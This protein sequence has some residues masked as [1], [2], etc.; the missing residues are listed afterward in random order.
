MNSEL[1]TTSARQLAAVRDS[2]LVQIDLV[3]NPRRIRVAGLSSWAIRDTVINDVVAA[4]PQNIEWY[5]AAL[6]GSTHLM[7][8]RG[9]ITESDEE[10]ILDVAGVAAGYRGAGAIDASSILAHLGFGPDGQEFD[11]RKEAILTRIS[12]PPAHLVGA[13]AWRARYNIARAW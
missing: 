9:R 10:F 13:D 12:T 6:N 2:T 5:R 8:L 1:A 3:D 4:L 11:A 7:T